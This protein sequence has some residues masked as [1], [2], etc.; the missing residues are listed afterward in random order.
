MQTFHLFQHFLIILTQ[1]MQNISESLNEIFGILMELGLLDVN[2]LI[3]DESL[4]LWSLHFYQPYNKN[5]NSFEIFKIDGF[6]SENY[7]NQLDMSINDLFPR[8]HFTF[9]KC[10]LYIST[11]SFE[12]FVIILEASNG[13]ITYDGI[14]IIIVNEISKTLNLIPT[15]KQQHTRG[16][17]FKNGSSTGALKMVIVCGDIF[18]F[19]ANHKTNF[20]I[21]I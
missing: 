4:N 16:M 12:P 10:S 3:K 14:D 8:K 6:S 19:M 20:I 7:T 9:C 13:S 11:F 21:P 2:I 5:C 17:I 1:S 18:Y 15:F